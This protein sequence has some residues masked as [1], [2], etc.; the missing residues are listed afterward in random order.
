MKK[1]RWYL[2]KT[3]Y[4]WENKIEFYK[5]NSLIS[6]YINWEKEDKIQTCA[7]Y[8]LTDFDIVDWYSQWMKKGIDKY[9]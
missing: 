7:S 5:T 3:I 9:E 4:I 6:V 8:D 2:I 1:A